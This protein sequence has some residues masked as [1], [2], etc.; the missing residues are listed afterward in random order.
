MT[1]H[2]LLGQGRKSWLNPRRIHSRA[3]SQ[4]CSRSHACDVLSELSLPTPRDD[5]RLNRK[6]AMRTVMSVDASQTLC[7]V[8]HQSKQASQP[9]ERQTRIKQPCKSRLNGLL[10]AKRAAVVKVS[11]TSALPRRPWGGLALL[12]SEGSL[13]W[14]HAAIWPA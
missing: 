12:A 3:S 10:R 11:G 5:D 4:E 9:I 14:H 8:G 7:D 2:E 1:R 13:E 6:R